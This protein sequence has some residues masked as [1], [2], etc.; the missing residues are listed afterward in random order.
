MLRTAENEDRN[1]RDSEVTRCA[2]LLFFYGADEIEDGLLFQ[3]S[4]KLPAGDDRCQPI[5]LV[6]HQ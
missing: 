1:Y 3:T 5:A 6:K 2:T 4:G